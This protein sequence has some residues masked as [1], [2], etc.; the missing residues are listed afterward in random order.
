MVLQATAPRGRLRNN[1]TEYEGY[2][3]QWD[4][5]PGG[6]IPLDY[7]RRHPAYCTD[8]RLT[9][10]SCDTKKR[11]AFVQQH[12]KQGCRVFDPLVDWET[13]P[14][15]YG[16]KVATP[17]STEPE[18]EGND[19]ESLT[20]RLVEALERFRAHGLERIR[21][22]LAAGE[23]LTEVKDQLG[24]GHF[25]EYLDAHK[26][27]SSTANRWMALWNSGLSAEAVEGMGGIKK[28]SEQLRRRRNA[29]EPDVG[30]L[31]TVGNFP[32]ADHVSA[33]RECPAC[34]TEYFGPLRQDGDLCIGCDGEV[35]VMKHVFQGDAQSPVEGAALRP[36]RG[37]H[38]CMTCRNTARRGSEFCRP[39]EY[40]T[41]A[42]L[43]EDA[44]MVTTL[45]RENHRLRKALKGLKYQLY[46]NT[47]KP[48][49]KA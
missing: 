20:G 18:D 30:K 17:I 15:R 32:V 21:A 6:D 33:S 43:G 36:P 4:E 19:L 3:E 31:P 46:G 10:Y 11:A 35:A 37:L 24:H 29:E 45:I 41:A 25:G 28:A 13:S 26:L 48:G 49:R 40:A 47:R 16:P 7:S 34:G 42:D 9:Q 12:Q 39:C 44:P 38:E 22:A 23:A 1:R 8:C 27:K 5:M 14:T 2:R